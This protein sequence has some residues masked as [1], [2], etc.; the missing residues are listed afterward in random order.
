[1]G[2]TARRSPEPPRLKPFP[3]RALPLEPS[4]IKMG[5][6]AVRRSPV[7]KNAGRPEPSR[8]VISFGGLDLWPIVVGCDFPLLVIGEEFGQRARFTLLLRRRRRDVDEAQRLRQPAGTIEKALGLLGH[9]GLLQMVDQLRRRLAFRFSNGLQNTGLGDPAEIVVD[10]WSPPGLD[11]VE[12][13]GTRQHV[14]LIKSRADAV[15]RDTALI[16]SG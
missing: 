8:D 1:M 11:H 9:I 2:R 6:D 4:P 3:A 13:D 7:T 16:G 15:G 14:G 10:R 5:T 12:S